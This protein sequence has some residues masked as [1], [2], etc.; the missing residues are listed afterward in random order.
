MNRTGQNH[1]LRFGTNLTVALEDY[2]VEEDAQELGDDMRVTLRLRQW[3]PY[4][5]KTVTE[6]AGGSKAQPQRETSGAPSAST[7]TAV[8]YTHL[9]LGE[10]R[11]LRRVRTVIG[12]EGVPV[13]VRNLPNARLLDNQYARLLDQK[14]N[15]LLGKPPVF[16]GEDRAA[17]AAVQETLGPQFFRALRGMAHDALAGGTGWLFVSPGEQ[18]GLRLRRFRPWEVLPFWADESR[19][20]LEAALRVWEREEDRGGRRVRAG[21]AE[22]YTEEGVYRFRREGRALVREKPF[23]SPSVRADTGARQLDLCWGRLPLLAVKNGPAGVPLLAR[24]K[25]LQDAVNLILSNFV[26]AMQ[27]L[28]LIHI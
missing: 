3:K 1:S 11:I 23:F 19:T 10:Q 18:G 27:E 17:A 14:V 7:Y 8:S 24:V 16:A 2:I 15:Y 22:L 26:N 12:P 13:E 20:E 5:V 25:S 4:A 21:Y 9:Y 6:T 28:S